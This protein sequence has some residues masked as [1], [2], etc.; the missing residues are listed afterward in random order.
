MQSVYI[1]G[2]I[3]VAIWLYVARQCWLSRDAP[4]LEQRSQGGYG[5]D[6]TPGDDGQDRS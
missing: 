3:C 4:T 5:E 2:A 6:G 1:F